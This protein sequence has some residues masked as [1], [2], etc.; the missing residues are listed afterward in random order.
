MTRYVEGKTT[1]TTKRNLKRQ[2]ASEPD[3]TRIVESSDWEFKTIIIHML[4]ALM[5]KVDSMKNRWA[6]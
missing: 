4:R 1:T 6:R 3:M 2:K 5:T